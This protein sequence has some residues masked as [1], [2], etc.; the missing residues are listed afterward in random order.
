MG[1][2]TKAAAQLK[3]LREH[4][5]LSVQEFADLVD[6]KRQAVSRWEHGGTSLSLRIFD[7]V[8]EKLGVD[9]E[10]VMCGNPE[11]KIEKKPAPKKKAEG[12]DK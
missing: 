11:I 10:A 5:G 4:N 12:K 6:L 8:C 1:I 3:R 2:S 9:A 7:Q